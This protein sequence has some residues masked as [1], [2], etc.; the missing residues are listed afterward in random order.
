MSSTCA[1]LGTRHFPMEP[2]ERLHVLEVLP[3]LQRSAGPES[4][5]VQRSSPL[6]HAA[7]L[8][9]SWTSCCREAVDSSAAGFEVLK[10]SALQALSVISLIFSSHRYQ[11]RNHAG[12]LC[13][14]TSFCSNRN[15][16]NLLSACMFG[17]RLLAS[18]FIQL[19][20]SQKYARINFFCL[21]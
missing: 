6:P 15:C 8:P 5:I 14:L 7:K 16:E 4:K 21:I 2:M 1:P 20:Y 19:F 10:I 11:A 17:Q 12:G 9:C 3:E 18:D 13:N